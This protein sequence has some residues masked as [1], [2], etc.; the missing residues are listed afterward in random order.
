VLP[1]VLFC[2]GGATIEKSA[3]T[4]SNG[5]QLSVAHSRLSFSTEKR[6]DPRNVG[7]MLRWVSASYRKKS[8]GGRRWLGVRVHPLLR[9]GHREA[10]KKRSGSWEGRRKAPGD[11]KETTLPA[12]KKNSVPAPEKSPAAPPQKKTTTRSQTPSETKTLS[13]A[14][15]RGGP[16]NDT[17]TGGG[18]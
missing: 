2:K 16:G 12:C 10:A 5:D 6:T 18:A 11:G 4:S 7:E 1:A 8:S 13:L 3:S 15:G 9:G 17:K 14:A